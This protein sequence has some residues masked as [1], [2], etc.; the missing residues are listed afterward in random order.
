MRSVNRNLKTLTWLIYLLLVIVGSS[1][2]LYFLWPQTA[3]FFPPHEIL[4]QYGGV[5]TLLLW[6]KILGFFV[7]ALPVTILC[8]ALLLAL[9]LVNFLKAGLWFD[10]RCETL[11]RSFSKVMLWFVLLQ[12]IHRTL[13]VLVITATNPPGEKQL[14]IS[15]STEDI[16]ALVPVV[17]ALI[18]AHIISLARE[19]REEL[20]QIV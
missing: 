4:T 13:L 5:D 7:A 16:F 8:W 19:Q 11:C 2:F 14:L 20:K 3:A 1:P 6:Q 12:F 17:F 10:E 18:F 9:K 15:I